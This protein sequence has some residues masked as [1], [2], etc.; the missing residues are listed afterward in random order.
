M[1]IRATEAEA[2][3]CDNTSARRRGEQPGETA[4]QVN[5]PKGIVEQQ[6]RRDSTGV[7]GLGQ[8]ALGEETAFLDPNP[9]FLFSDFYRQRFG[10]GDFFVSGQEL[11]LRDKVPQKPRCGDCNNDRGKQ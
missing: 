5:A 4:A 6:D 1:R 11:A 8:P 9:A 10:H 3:I 2:V 7:G